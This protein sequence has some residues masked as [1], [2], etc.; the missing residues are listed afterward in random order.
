ME[1]SPVDN[2]NVNKQDW[3]YDNSQPNGDSSLADLAQ[4]TTSIKVN[5]TVKPDLPPRPDNKTKKETAD[6][7]VES[8]DNK[9]KKT[10]NNQNDS[11]NSIKDKKDAEKDKPKKSHK[12]L[13]IGGIATFATGAVILA[14]AYFG[15]S[16]TSN[17]GPEQSQS[18]SAPAPEHNANKPTAKP[19]QPDNKQN[20]DDR[21]K[22]IY[23]SDIAKELGYKTVGEA[24]IQDREDLDKLINMHAKEIGYHECTIDSDY[25]VSHDG[26]DIDCEFNGNTT[27]GTVIVRTHHDSD[28]FDI[29]YMKQNHSSNNNGLHKTKSDYF[30]TP[31]EAEK[32]V[33]DELVNK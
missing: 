24:G 4:E 25:E 26:I 2:D 5:N 23:A 30:P 7:K 27:S 12:G 18:N 31:K 8:D 20:K 6:S 16:K 13:V 22:G 29:D 10:D 15:N 21:Q 33:I 17:K 14:G 1:K 28:E 3:S 32:I 11:K 19:Q 9:D